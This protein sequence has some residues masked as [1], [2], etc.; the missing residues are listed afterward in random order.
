MLLS[1]R[2]DG[3]GGAQLLAF[4]LACIVLVNVLWLTG[5]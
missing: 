4:T 5:R 1:G 2:T 3:P